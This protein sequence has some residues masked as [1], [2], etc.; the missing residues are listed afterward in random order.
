MFFSRWLP[1]A[2]S[3]SSLKDCGSPS[4]NSAPYFR[5]RCQAPFPGL[6]RRV[7]LEAMDALRQRERGTVVGSSF[8]RCGER[9]LGLVPAPRPIG[10]Q[11]FGIAPRAPAPGAGARASVL[12]MIS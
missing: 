3:F 9:G 6:R 8:E 11:S 12:P 7:G 5:S 1:S 10:R 4:F 2:S